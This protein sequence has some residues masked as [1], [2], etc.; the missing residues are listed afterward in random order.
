MRYAIAAVLSLIA[1]PALAYTD[2]GAPMNLQIPALGESGNSWAA[3]M[4]YN[5]MKLSTASASSGGSLTVVPVWGKIQVDTITARGTNI[6]L[7]SPVVTGSSLTSSGSITAYSSVT[8]NAFFGTHH[9]DGSNLTGVV[10]SSTFSLLYA[11]TTMSIGPGTT[12]YWD[13]SAV[14]VGSSTQTVWIPT[15]SGTNSDMSACIAGSTITKNFSGGTCAKICYGGGIDSDST[16]NRGAAP[17]VDGAFWGGRTNQDM[18]WG[19]YGVASD[20]MYAGACY[21]Y[22]TAVTKGA[23]TYCL[24]GRRSAGTW[25]IFGNSNFQ[26]VFRIEEVKC[27]TGASW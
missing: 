5:F 14:G 4:R 12:V 18:F 17:L 11:T 20:L 10:A 26:N 25:H 21:Q 3:S 6:Y 27:D 8:A 19:G 2:G 16:G 15:A 23:H 9:G 24:M 22:N 13:A 7:S 1:S